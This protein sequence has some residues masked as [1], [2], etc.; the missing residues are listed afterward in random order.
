LLKRIS[1]SNKEDAKQ[2]INK[3]Y[4]LI[5][6]YSRKV[7]EGKGCKELIENR[8]PKII[9]TSIPRGS[10][11]TVYQA[12]QVCHATSKQIRAW[13]HKGK[14]EAFNLPGLGIIIEAGKL[15]DFLYEIRSIQD[16]PTPEISHEP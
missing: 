12:A 9:P 5:A 6:G 10:Y 1:S 7:R 2:A 13:I 15:N 14:L 16:S 11:F 3:V 8:E 4:R